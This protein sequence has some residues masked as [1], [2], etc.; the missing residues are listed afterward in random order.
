M[1]SESYSMRQFVEAVKEMDY[2][3]MVYCAVQEATEAERIAYRAKGGRVSS[4]EESRKYADRL[5]CFIRFMQYGVRSSGLS[6]SDFELF[7]SLCEEYVKRTQIEA[8]C[9]SAF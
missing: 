6:Y 9:H 3:D 4:E 7:R 8:R 2:L 1:I 5:K